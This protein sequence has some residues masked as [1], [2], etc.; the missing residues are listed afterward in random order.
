MVCAARTIAFEPFGLG[1]IDSRN[2]FVR[3][4]YLPSVFFR[5]FCCPATVKTAMFIVDDS[6]CL[7]DQGRIDRRRST[8]WRLR[9]SRQMRV[10]LLNGGRDVSFFGW[11]LFLPTA[12]TPLVRIPGPVYGLENVYFEVGRM[13]FFG[14]PIV[15]GWAI[16]RVAARQRT[17]APVP[18]PTTLTDTPF[19][20][21][22]LAH[23]PGPLPSLP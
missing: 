21:R 14:A 22:S 15:I 19:P 10:M 1:A 16:G 20:S 3:R 9:H 13:I 5:P 6:T 7:G 11:K 17:K 8:I 23:D 2:I 4:K 12:A 18:L